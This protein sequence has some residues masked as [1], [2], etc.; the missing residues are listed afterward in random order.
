MG[1][2]W[3][4]RLVCSPL[5]ELY[6][7]WMSTILSALGMI[8]KFYWWPSISFSKE[9]TYSHRVI[10]TYLLND[11]TSSRGRDVLGVALGDVLGV[12]VLI[13]ILRS[14]RAA[15]FNDCIVPYLERQTTPSAN[16]EINKIT[17]PSRHRI[18]NSS[19]GGLTPSTLP[20]SHGGS[21]APRRT[22]V[23]PTFQADRFINTA[24]APPPYPNCSN[25]EYTN[26]KERL[27]KM[28]VK[29]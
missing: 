7:R 21:S 17:L 20:L 5:A 22:H 27:E 28:S 29:K 26:S 12:A 4:L 8:I 15:T 11:L 2:G 9:H 1:S 6:Q 3:C 16:D 25:W 13:H 19:P 23:L 24:S 18:R 14:G 10:Q